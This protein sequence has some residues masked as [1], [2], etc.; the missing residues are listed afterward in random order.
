MKNY[1]WTPRGREIE[2]RCLVGIFFLA[3][4]GVVAVIIEI[5]KWVVSLF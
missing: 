5:F 3:F 2:E 1:Y 4:C